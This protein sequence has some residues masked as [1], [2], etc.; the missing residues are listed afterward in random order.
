MTTVL[1]ASTICIHCGYHLVGLMSDADCPECG[2]SCKD[3]LTDDN[4]YEADFGFIS[5]L[6]LGT[7]LVL[8]G[9]YTYLLGVLFRVLAVWTIT[10]GL[11]TPAAIPFGIPNATGRLLLAVG[12]TLWV[13]GWFIA[14]PFDTAPG[15]EKEQRSTRNI[16]RSVI[17]AAYIL[18]TIGFV[19]DQAVVIFFAIFGMA[20]AGFIAYFVTLNWMKRQVMR[21]GDHDLVKSIR[22]AKLAGVLAIVLSLLSFAIFVH[23]ARTQADTTIDPVASDVYTA[24]AGIVL[25]LGLVAGIAGYFPIV[26]SFAKAMK[27]AKQRAE[28]LQYAGTRS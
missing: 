2:E 19:F 8:Y 23:A 21:A 27:L 11:R 24:L 4:L 6:S 1:S 25:L 17:V 26:H 9:Q 10:P 28:P 14:T 18:H 22:L 15:A 7:K 16:L 20:M 12:S 5:R 13:V 3:S